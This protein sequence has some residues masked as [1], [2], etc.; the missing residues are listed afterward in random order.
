MRGKAFAVSPDTVACSRV[1]QPPH[2]HPQHLVPLLSTMTHTGVLVGPQEC[3]QP[4]AA[5]R[6]LF[7][8]GLDLPLPY[9]HHHAVLFVLATAFQ[10]AAA[11]YMKSGVCA[12]LL[13]LRLLQQPPYVPCTIR[14]P[15]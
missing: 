13:F 3:W 2:L 11:C 12:L 15:C 6:A 1:F 5:C 4:V 7:H 8:V 14:S 10:F 9:G